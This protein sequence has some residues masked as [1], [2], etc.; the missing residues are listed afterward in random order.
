MESLEVQVVSR[1]GRSGP[2][3]PIAAVSPRDPGRTDAS[4]RNAKY[5]NEIRDSVTKFDT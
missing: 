1:E 5:C 2:V 3:L 4:D